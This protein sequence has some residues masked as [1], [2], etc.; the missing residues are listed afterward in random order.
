LTNQDLDDYLDEGKWYYADGGNRVTH[1]PS[2]V[3]AFELYV[4]R[5]ANGYRY[6]KLI[7]S[8]GIIWF[9]YYDSTAWKTWVRWYTDQ[10][11]D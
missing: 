9:R 3:D 7:T 10:N 8:N 5:N 2:G 4:G 11:T 6:Q 1:K